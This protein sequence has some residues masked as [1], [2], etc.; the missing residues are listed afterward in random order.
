MLA[1]LCHRFERLQQHDAGRKVALCL[2]IG[3]YQ[4]PVIPA[5][6]RGTGTGHRVV[7]GQH[8]DVE[9]DDVSG[10]MRIISVGAAQLVRLVQVALVT[11]VSCQSV[12]CPLANGQI[13]I[14]EI[15]QLSKSSTFPTDETVGNI[16]SRLGKIGSRAE[17]SRAEQSRA[18]QSRAEQSRAEQSRAEQRNSNKT[19]PL[20]GYWTCQ[21]DNIRKCARRNT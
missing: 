17:Q 19:R 1:L 13:L 7:L 9:L 14:I 2:S 4:T 10:A 6:V 5:H 20:V 15:G 11:V 8:D 18:E 3:R 21:C 12:C 16:G